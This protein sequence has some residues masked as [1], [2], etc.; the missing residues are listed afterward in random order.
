MDDPYANL[1][2]KFTPPQANPYAGFTPVGPVN[3]VAVSKNRQA[4]NEGNASDYAPGKANE[5][6]VGQRTQNAI[7]RH[8]LTTIDRAPPPTGYRYKPDGTLDAIPGGPAAPVTIAPNSKVHGDDYLKSVPANMAATV[9]GVASG[10]VM[11]PP[12]ALKTP[13]WQ[14]VLQHTLNYDPSFNAADYNTRAR[15]RQ[16]WATGKMGV[17][18]TALN[19]ALGH[20]GEVMNDVSKL[21]NSGGL[22]GTSIWNPIAN[23]FLSM[24]GDPRTTNFDN[25]TRAFGS[26]LSKVF[27]GA[28]GSQGE[29]NEWRTSIP[30]NGSPDQQR[31]VLQQDAKLLRSRL[32][33]INQQYKRG[34]GHTAD[35]TELLD[36]HARQVY[37]SLLGVQ[38][39]AVG[40]AAPKVAPSNGGGH[41]TK[42]RDGVMEWHP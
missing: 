34:M 7:K 9:K 13:Y 5:D 2:T 3:P 11:L 41:F 32:E 37:N 19:T 33:A 15:T 18:I 22:F 17:N 30:L 8:E 38:A 40:G 4:I 28:Q 27:S 42:G 14:Q 36:P 26:E 39:P 1:Y 25:D 16:D 20:G 24:S 12:F 29:R 35:I 31:G 6:L 10:N 23:K 21:N